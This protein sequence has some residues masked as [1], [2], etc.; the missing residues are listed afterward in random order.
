MILYA[1]ITL[2]IILYLMHL[3]TQLTVETYRRDWEK[4]EG[5]D[6]FP[7]TPVWLQKPGGPRLRADFFEVSPQRDVAV[8]ITHG[9]GGSRVFAQSWALVFLRAGI[10]AMTLDFRGYGE[11]DGRISTVAWREQDDVL[12]AAEW[13]KEEAGFKRVVA[14][15]LSM[16]G[17]A[18]IL[19]AARDKRLIDGVISDCAFA[20]MDEAMKHTARLVG[21]PQLMATLAQMGV[22]WRFGLRPETVSP[23]DAIARLAP[24]PVLIIHG[25]DDPLIPESDAQR[26]F[27][28]AGQPKSLWIAPDI[29]HGRAIWDAAEEYRERVVKFI[30]ELNRV[31]S[32]VHHS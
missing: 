14:F 21:M 13:L 30:E 23:E 28:R 5:I 20:R 24:R 7:L 4:A 22:R 18:C 16:G 1:A 11:S 25:D 15:G 9:R 31:E 26:L 8:L 12:T 17:A 27:K 3:A 32:D 10:S 29:G 19:A 2:G 6:D